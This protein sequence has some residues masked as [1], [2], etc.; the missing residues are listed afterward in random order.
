[1]K[2]RRLYVRDY[3]GIEERDVEIPDSGV[4]I[5]GG[6]MRGK[7]SVLNAIRA[8]L[9]GA[10]IGPDAIRIGADRAEILVNLDA[11]T[12]RRVIKATG[13]D[14]TVTSEGA[15]IK[16]P[17]TR[18]TELL[19]NAPFDPL[20]LYHAKPKDRRQLVLQAVHVTA[21]PEDVARW[22]GP[23]TS[24]STEGHGLDV[25]E[26]LHGIFYD[27]R[28]LANATADEAKRRASVAEA[29]LPERIE[30][31]M[32]ETAAAVALDA[33]I[34]AH[35][36]VSERY[37]QAQRAEAQRA[38]LAVASIPTDDEVETAAIELRSSQATV[39]AAH[40]EIARLEA[41][42]VEARA[43][44][45]RCQRHADGAR[46]R[47]TELQRVRGEHR[48]K[49]EAVAALDVGGPTGEELAAAREAEEEARD[50]LDRARRAEAFAN[51]KRDAERMRETA[52]RCEADAKALDSVVK[53][54][55]DDAPIELLARAHGGIQGLTVKGDDVLLDGVS[56]DGLSGAERVWF[57]VQIAKRL[58]ERTRILVVDGLEALDPE[59]LEAFVKHATADDWQLIATRVD[60]GD[61]VFE[62]FA[63][64]EAS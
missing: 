1:M 54:L 8:A 39:T 55:R 33:A 49:L 56:L 40:A 63:A 15:P 12:V 44:Q 47:L 46:V 41:A 61:V 17:Q 53:R 25:I 4:L 27:R 36:R 45:V 38:E 37:Q 6:N 9:G 62:A 21:T 58:N 48:A 5:R 26:K 3:R 34:A 57:C 18:L 14:L 19:G 22:V 32:T 59:E 7:T 11:L 52:K 23:G 50:A 13:A 60:R 29:G 10:D 2:I 20:D 35:A 30:C 42:L 51:A 16:K 64:P 43:Q 24:V 31:A 28:K